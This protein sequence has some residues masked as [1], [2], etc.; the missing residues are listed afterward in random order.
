MS[1]YGTPILLETASIIRADLQERGL[2]GGNAEKALIRSLAGTQMVL[3]FEQVNASI[4]A[5]QVD[6]LIDLNSQPE[7]APLAE[8]QTL[9]DEARRAWKD[10]YHGHTLDSWIGFLESYKLVELRDDHSVVLTRL[11]REFL[12]WRIETGKPGPFFG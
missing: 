11:G 4:Y 8:A 7:G 1:T 3:H 5:S 2:A 12:K 9:Y 10:L 6:L